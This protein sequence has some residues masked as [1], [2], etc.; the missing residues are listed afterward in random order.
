MRKVFTNL[1]LAILGATAAP[2]IQAQTPRDLSGTVTAVP[3]GDEIEI[4][5]TRIRLQGIAAPGPYM[6]LGG[7]ATA[8]MQLLVLQ[9]EVTCHLTGEKTRGREV[10]SCE[11]NGVDIASVIVREGLARDCPRF[12]RGR[13]AKDERAAKDTGLLDAYPLPSY[14][15]SGV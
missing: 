11:W 6:P 8:F 7:D 1:V 9:K 12:S 15:G 13:Y 10:G 2:A 4:D 14:C 5:G 3:S